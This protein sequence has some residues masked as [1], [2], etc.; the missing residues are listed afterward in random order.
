MHHQNAWRQTAGKMGIHLRSDYN[1][2]EYVV[3]TFAAVRLKTDREPHYGRTTILEKPSEIFND[4]EVRPPLLS[5]LDLI[6]RRSF[7]P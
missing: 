6:F 1:D 3:R 2:A 5:P 4:L 7:I